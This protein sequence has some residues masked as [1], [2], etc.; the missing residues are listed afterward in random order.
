M[1]RLRVGMRKQ[2]RNSWRERDRKRGER[3]TKRERERTILLI[4]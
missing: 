2:K 1:E 3:E 4:D